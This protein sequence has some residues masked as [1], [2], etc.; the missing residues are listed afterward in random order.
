MREGD[1]D[2][3]PAAD[4]PAEDPETARR[5]FAAALAQAAVAEAVYEVLD[6]ARRDGVDL[7]DGFAERMARAAARRAGVSLR[8]LAAQSVRRDDGE[9]VSAV[10]KMRQVF[11]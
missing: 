5:E 3:E 7:P 9:G 8:R 6:E 2:G 10:R 1:E 11:A 4:E